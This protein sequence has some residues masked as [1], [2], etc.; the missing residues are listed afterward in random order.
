M[1]DD[2]RS[3]TADPPENLAESPDRDEEPFPFLDDGDSVF[4]SIVVGG[5]PDDQAADQQE[6]DE[7]PEE[8][9]PEPVQETR[10]AAALLVTP[11][12]GKPREIP[13][14]EHRSILGRGAADVVLD[15]PFVS[16]HH[17]Q[18]FWDDDALVL[19]DL[20]SYNG[21]FLGIANDL[22]LEDLDELVVGQQRFVFRNT[23][24]DPETDDS[25]DVSVPK[26]GAPIGR[27]PVRL[28]RYLE[29]GRLAGVF[30]V[31]DRLTIGSDAGDIVFPDDY[32]LSSPH[33]AVLRDGESFV[34][35]DLDSDG[36][37]FLRIRDPVELV[38]GDRFVIGRTHVDVAFH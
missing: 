17:A 8:I 38:D 36:G 7:G 4:S 18:L 34:L 20:E 23:W 28:L 13:V 10:T 31:G 14:G 21:V 29:G 26:L 24:E 9:E 19:D 1:P 27:P 11:P 35:R 25:R 32:E 22:A 5:D 16:P 30:R 15:D 37:T 6:Q 33:A 2:P 12:E 3:S